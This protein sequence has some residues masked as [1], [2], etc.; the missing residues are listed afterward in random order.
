MVQLTNGDRLPLLSED[1][2]SVSDFEY[3]AA[4]R[5]AGQRNEPPTISDQRQPNARVTIPRQLDEDGEVPITKFT[6]YFGSFLAF[7]SGL[8]TTVNNFIIKETGSDFGELLAVRSLIQIPLMLGIAVYKGYPLL[9]KGKKQKALAFLMGLFGAV[10][11]LT[12]FSCVK[13]MPVGDAMTLIFTNPLFTMIF[14]ALFMKQDVTIIKFVAGTGLMGG[15][16]LVMKPPILFP[17][18]HHPHPNDTHHDHFHTNHS[19]DHYHYLYAFP[20]GLEA[21]HSHNS[22]HY[23]PYPPEPTPR[24]TPVDP[25]YDLYF[26]GALLATGCAVVAAANN[27]V[28]AKLQDVKPLV[29]LLYVGIG[30]FFVAM[31]CELFDSNDKFF[32]SKITEITATQALIYIALSLSG[33]FCYFCMIVSLVLKVPPATVSTLRTL[34]IIVAFVVQVFVSHTMPGFVDLLG[35]ALVFVCALVITFENKIGLFIENTCCSRN[36]LLRNSYEEI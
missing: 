30:A 17:P 3:E 23:Y 24:P 1:Q 25:T 34:Q 31:G 5:Q 13:F 12:A 26:L 21:G 29:Q 27:I 28:I 4:L 11:M 15:I 35:A 9:P 6:F 16:I 32:T 18:H 14:A 10:T 7:F 20:S 36:T 8:I 2:T 22:S 19:H 33:M